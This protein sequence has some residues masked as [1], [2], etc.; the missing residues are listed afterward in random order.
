MKKAKTGTCKGD[1]HLTKAFT[2]GA[3][4]SKS[5]QNVS[6]SA[7]NSSFTKSIEK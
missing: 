2:F 6:W 1:I 5:F 3:A 7:N 4:F